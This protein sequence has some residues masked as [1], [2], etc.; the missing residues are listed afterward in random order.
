MTKPAIVVISQA[1]CQVRYPAD[2]LY[3]PSFTSCISN[4]FTSAMKYSFPSSTLPTGFCRI[5][6]N[7]RLPFLLEYGIAASYQLTLF[8]FWC[9]QY[10]L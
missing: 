1:L 2:R 5:G 9:M 7:R 4:I 8:S 3:T 6:K 10:L